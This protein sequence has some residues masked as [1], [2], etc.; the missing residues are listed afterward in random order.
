ME[1]KKW[2]VVLIVVGVL[3]LAFVLL[4]S[5]LHIYGNSFGIR[6]IVGTIV[7]AAVL[8]VGIIVCLVPRPRS[9]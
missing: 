7:S 3:M 1:T 4:A 8:V 5:P 2:G 9:S 6:H